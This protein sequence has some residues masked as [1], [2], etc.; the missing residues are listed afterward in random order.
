MFSLS[1]AILRSPVLHTACKQANVSG[2]HW[3]LMCYDLLELDP[4]KP[5]ETLSAWLHESIHSRQLCKTTYGLFILFTSMDQGFR[6]IKAFQ[7]E[8]PIIV[9]GC[10][11]GSFDPLDHGLPFRDIKETDIK[12]WLCLEAIR[13]IFDGDQTNLLKSESGLDELQYTFDSIYNTD[14]FGAVPSSL[15]KFD[16]YPR[17]Q[18]GSQQF[19]L[20]CISPFDDS[21]H[22]IGARSLLEG[23]A[24]ASQLLLKF[25]DT[26]RIEHGQSVYRSAQRLFCK[27]FADPFNLLLPKSMRKDNTSLSSGDRLPLSYYLNNAGN[28]SPNAFRLVF[29]FCIVVE[30]ALNAPL[31]PLFKS[32]VNK[33]NLKWH[34]LHPGW[35][36]VKILSKAEDLLKRNDKL[37][38]LSRWLIEPDNFIKMIC[39]EL[40]WPNRNHL[41]DSLRTAIREEF[42]VDGVPY[43]IKGDKFRFTTRVLHVAMGLAKPGS[44]IPFILLFNE[45]TL[46]AD[47]WDF[48]QHI[49]SFKSKRQLWRDSWPE[50]WNDYYTY[51]QSI[52]IDW[53][54]GMCLWEFLA[55]WSKAPDN[56]RYYINTPYKWTADECSEILNYANRPLDIGETVNTEFF[57]LEVLRMMMLGSHGSNPAEHL[58]ELICDPKCERYPIVLTAC[59][60]MIN[61]IFTDCVYPGH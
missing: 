3:P 48:L 21:F 50:E 37:K 9:E 15:F 38:T 35:R 2:Y 40:N 55:A 46:D 45:K 60:N 39:E 20:T 61:D 36:F 56:L 6:S 34:D 41:F 28:L 47:D 53:K 22:K 30:L 49:E 31:T 27:I 14:E 17:I 29:L 54:R 7:K 5:T 8:H 16:S 12:Q 52:T 19:D 13:R 25:D 57:H 4:K 43:T 32:L 58:A 42:E 1:H 24:M 51:D 59:K 23:S 26:T 18:I 44:W 33:Y 11:F 10:M